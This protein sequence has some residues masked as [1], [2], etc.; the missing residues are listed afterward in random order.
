MTIT[1]SHLDYFTRN[2]L[3]ARPGYRSSVADLDVDVDQVLGW[4]SAQR[5]R[6]P[7]ADDVRNW[8]RTD[9]H[10]AITRT[11]STAVDALEWAV[12]AA[13]DLVAGRTG[14]GVRPV[15]ADGVFDPDA[16]A[17]LVP[18]RV[19][20]AAVMMAARLYRRKD[21]AEGIYGTSEVAGGIAIKG[22]DPDV[23]RLLELPPSL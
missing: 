10:T 6:W 3:T 11:D 19:H 16:E 18:P 2:I 1:D 9:G 21:S 22:L 5:V 12:A 15:D 8:S 13:V 7:T 4:G 14:F 17:V 23:E 20:L